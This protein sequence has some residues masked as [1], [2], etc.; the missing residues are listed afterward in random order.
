MG[1]GLVGVHAREGTALAQALA[2]VEAAVVVDGH[3][4]VLA[5]LVDVG[6][7][8]V[9]A[10]A[11][12]DVHDARPLVGAHVVG[13]DGDA[14]LPLEDG[15]RVVQAG[16][17][18]AG[19]RPLLAAHAHEL[20]VPPGDLAEALGELAH[21]DLGAALPGDGHVLGVALQ[22]HGLVGRD[23]PG[24]GGPDHEV[25]RAVEALEAG[26]GLD[27]LEAHEDRGAHLVGVLDLGLG[28]GSVAVLAPVHRLAAAIDHAAV[29][30]GL[31]DLDVGRVVLVVEREVGVVPVTK[32]AQALEAL[33]LQV[34]VLHRELAA[35]L[36]DL[37][38]RRVVELLGAQG[39]LDLVLD[40][41]AVA[42]PAGDVGRLPALH[43][44]VAADDVLG[45]LVHGMAHVDGAV[46]IGRSVV[47]DELVVTLVLLLQQL[48]DVVLLPHGQALRLALRKAAAHREIRLGQVH[49]VLVVTCHLVRP[50]P[51]GPT[52]P[53]ESGAQ[54]RRPSPRAGT[55]RLNIRQRALASVVAR[56]TRGE[57]NGQG[58]ALTT[59]R[60]ELRCTRLTCDGGH[61]DDVYSRGTQLP[62]FGA[63]AP[64]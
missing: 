61:S 43:G 5:H 33:A 40:G 39:L 31:E 53:V 10:V 12:S 58:F 46:G 41:L 20:Q 29:V 3:D 28:Q 45:D 34:E 1:V 11:R 35:H 25:N 19:A 18:L 27:D 16:Q 32:H 62:R 44:P 51:S 4:E 15:V 26:H 42:V 55:K 59:Q 13:H 21:H 54:K 63:A 14:L 37:L 50:P 7:V 24:R 56:G 52:G 6:V 60:A 30:H 64:G 48:V 8:V 2:L 22:G 47:Q 23:G 9:G 57:V 36:A 17:A 38:D 49:R